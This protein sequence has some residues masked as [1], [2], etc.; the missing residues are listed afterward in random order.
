MVTD[1][2][3]RNP[4]APVRFARSEPAKS[5]CESAESHHLDEGRLVSCINCGDCSMTISDVDFIACR[6]LTYI[7]IF[8]LTLRMLNHS[9][10]KHSFYTLLM[11]S[12]RGKRTKWN[13]AV[14]QSVPTAPSWSARCSTI[15]VKIA[16]D[17]LDC[18]F[19]KVL[20]VV[21]KTDPCSKNL[22]SW[23][24][25]LFHCWKTAKVTWTIGSVYR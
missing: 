19:I 23:H 13:F 8:W 1:S 17:L 24:G 3:K 21:R 25:W 22:Q 15:M 20:P 16:C 14:M 5:T 18:W 6:A 7:R 11:D 2:L 10:D 12:E 9:L 4:T